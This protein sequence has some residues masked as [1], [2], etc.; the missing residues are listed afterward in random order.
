MKFFLELE[1]WWIFDDGTIPVLQG[2]GAAQCGMSHE[3]IS[4]DL[5]TPLK[6]F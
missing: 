3:K 1:D 6:P 4:Q 2:Y 5:P